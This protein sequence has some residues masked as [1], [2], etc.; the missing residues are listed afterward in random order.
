MLLMVVQRLLYK[1]LTKMIFSDT[2]I[3]GKK[4]FLRNLNVNA[5]NTTLDAWSTASSAYGFYDIPYEI[6]LGIYKKYYVRYT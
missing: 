4:I 3:E 2:I 5:Q 6:P 1:G